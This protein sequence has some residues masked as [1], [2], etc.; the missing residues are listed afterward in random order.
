MD[1]V[2]IPVERVC[3]GMYIAELD[4]PWLETPFPFQGFVV[5]TE[6]Q[7]ET[8]RRFCV[9]VTVDR[10][11]SDALPETHYAPG[12]ATQQ[13]HAATVEVRGNTQYV[14]S[15]EV[16]K[17]LPAAKRIRK[18]CE[19][20]VLGALN[21]VAA[22]QSIDPER[23]IGAVRAVSES[24]QRNPDAML[25]LTRLRRKGSYE[26]RRALDTSVLMVSFGRFLQLSQP[27]LELLGLAGLLQDIGKVRLP[28]TLLHKKKRFSDEERELVQKHVALSVE[29]LR[30]AK[31]FPDEL[32]ENVSLHHERYDGS[33]YPRAL[34]GRAIGLMGAIGGLADVYSALTSDRPYAEQMSPSNA[35]GMLHKSRGILFEEALIEQFIQCV[36][37]YPVGSVVE[38]NSGEIAIVIAQNRVRRLQPRVMVVLDKDHR[39]VSPQKILDLL[40]EPKAAPDEPYRI[41]RTLEPDKLKL[42]PREYFL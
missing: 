32:L 38:L 22:G 21:S 33:G 1:Q 39:P 37:I 26:L 36:G 23:L 9:R 41:R 40:K 30:D 8:L 25:L 4:R 24:I 13:G 5:R 15:R 19:K 3:F 16:E 2:I 27:Q 34:A 42:D 28:R 7:L 10:A 6:W 14:E 11:R 12:V 17:E 18:N 35:L 29:I 31:A 20:A